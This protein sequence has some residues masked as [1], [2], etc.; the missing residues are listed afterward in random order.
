MHSLWCIAFTTR[1]M[2]HSFARAEA[3]NL[4]QKLILLSW[5]VNN[6]SHY[7]HNNTAKCMQWEMTIYS[8]AW[9]FGLPWTTRCC[10]H[11]WRSKWW[12][13]WH[14]T[15]SRWQLPTYTGTDKILTYIHQAPGWLESNTSWSTC[16]SNILWSAN[17]KIYN[18][19]DISIDTN[20]NPE[21]HQ[22]GTRSRYKEIIFGPR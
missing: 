11:C 3:A 16:T 10:H 17:S 13:M 14:W 8:S 20:R 15:W 21:D 7:P 22:T 5:L 18:L 6:S 4:I 9:R 2:M 12:W 19:P 1:F